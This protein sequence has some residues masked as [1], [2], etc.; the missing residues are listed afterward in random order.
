MG[1]EEKPKESIEINEVPQQTEV[2]VSQQIAEKNEET[3]QITENVLSVS[4]NE[5]SVLPVRGRG[6]PRK[7]I[8]P[9]LANRPKKESWQ[10]KKANRSRGSKQAKK[11]SWQTKENQ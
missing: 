4:E 6:R 7:P 3:Q 2:V 10:T 5:N 11:E 9:E 8:D 1:S